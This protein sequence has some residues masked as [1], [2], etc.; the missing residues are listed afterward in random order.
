MQQPPA[1]AITDPMLGLLGPGVGHQHRPSGSSQRQIDEQA[2]RE[3]RDVQHS[4]V[5][6]ALGRSSSVWRA[7]RRSNP[8]RTTVPEGY[9]TSSTFADL[10]AARMVGQLAVEHQFITAIKLIRELASHNREVA[11][12][13]WVAGFWWGLGLAAAQ[14]LKNPQYDHTVVPV[15]LSTG[16]TTSTS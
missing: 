13:M 3:K 14:K 9:C 2:A 1:R 12:K 8:S 4:L 7:G 6:E 5:E 16:S 15:S 11:L 10:D